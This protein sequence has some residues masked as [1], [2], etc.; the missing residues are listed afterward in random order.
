MI[1]IRPHPVAQFVEWSPATFSTFAPR[2]PKERN[3]KKKPPVGRSFWT[4]CLQTVRA[5]PHSVSRRRRPTPACASHMITAALSID[6]YRAAPHNERTQ[7]R[8]TQTHEHIHSQAIQL[9]SHIRYSSDSNWLARAHAQPHSIKSLRVRTQPQGR[10]TYT[11]SC[12]SLRESPSHPSCDR[13]PSSR[14]TQHISHSDN[15]K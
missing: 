7:R 3:E 12:V 8:C 4:A 13:T 14:N 15:N 10:C 1:C 6:R 5:Q 2:T 11:T 9:I